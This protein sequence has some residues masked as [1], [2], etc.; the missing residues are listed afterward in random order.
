MFK[1][2][3]DGNGLVIYSDQPEGELLSSLPEHD[4]SE[5]SDS[6]TL[7]LEPSVTLKGA[8]AVK[9]NWNNMASF[10][11][12]KQMVDFSPFD[13]IRFGLFGS[14]IYNY[15]LDRHPNLML[16][17]VEAEYKELAGSTLPVALT[18]WTTLSGGDSSSVLNPFFFR[19]H[20]G[21]TDWQ[22]A[23]LS[24]ESAFLDDYSLQCPFKSLNF[25]PRD[26]SGAIQIGPSYE[27]FGCF[28]H[29][30]LWVYDGVSGYFAP[31]VFALSGGIGA[32]RR[33]SFHFASSQFWGG[34]QN[35]AE[36][37]QLYERPAPPDPV[38][39]VDPGDPDS[40]DFL[41]EFTGAR[42]DSYTIGLYTSSYYPTVDF[43]HSV[44]GDMNVLSGLAFAGT[45]AITSVDGIAG[46]V[47]V[48]YDTDYWHMGSNGGLFLFHADG[49]W[50]FD[51]FQMFYD[52]L[53]GETR[54]T[55]IDIGVSDEISDY[56]LR[57][58]V[59]VEGELQSDDPYLLRYTVLAVNS[60]EYDPDDPTKV[61]VS[62][63]VFSNAN[64]LSGW[65]VTAVRS[66]SGYVGTFVRSV[67]GYFNG[68]NVKIDANGDYQVRLDPS[69]VASPSLI[70]G[71]VYNTGVSFDATNG[72]NNKS[73]SINI[74][75]R[76]TK[77]PSFG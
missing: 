76:Y 13:M 45:A 70:D 11:R 39:P 36:L 29:V 62:G 77:P 73:S 2:T 50:R 8:F 34:F 54:E 27:I 21:S 7:P 30:G 67:G 32:V 31:P 4:G 47:S 22:V 42:A 59:P 26:E 6:D 18:M 19:E 65:T 40:Y 16:I 58:S 38:D 17:G 63:N 3:L 69:V 25:A 48:P 5:I 60:S 44:A 68:C 55:H 9:N 41:Y 28:K 20:T 23:H 35:S 14:Q 72:G 64:T 24:L 52:V 71:A 12:P 10:D 57:L 74:Y 37:I 15:L 66:S 53:P 1:A 75:L 33:M 49:F 61:V 56:T 46:G 43:Y 51:T